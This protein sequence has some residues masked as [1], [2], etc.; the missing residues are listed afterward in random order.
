MATDELTEYDIKRYNRQMMIKGF[1]EEGQKKL[2]STRVFVAGVGGLGCPVTTYLAV[3]GFGHITIADLDV[4]D[5]SNLNRQILHW[6]KDVGRVKVESGLEKLTAINPS[7]EVSAFHGRIDENN[8][9]DLTKGHDLIIDAMDNFPTRFLLNRAALKHGVPFIHASV[10]GMEGRITTIVPG[11]TPCL[12]CTFPHAPPKE[13]FPI[14]GATPGVLGTLQAI[15]AVKVVLGIG[16]TL[17]GRLLVFDGEYMEFHEIDLN[18]DPKCAACG[19]G[20][21]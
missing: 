16:R 6:D 15:E 2:K 5:L 17:E 21:K 11:K 12:E 4:V 1:G 7:I 14:L 13:V 19:H 9:Y 8:V 3:A 18:K 20:H 10:W